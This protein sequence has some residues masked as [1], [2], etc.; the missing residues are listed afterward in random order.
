M[1]YIH[2][3]YQHVEPFRFLDLPGELRNAIYSKI[4]NPSAC[5]IDLGDGKSRYEVPTA[6]FLA[7]KQISEEA[8][9]VFLKNFT[10]VR[11]E[12]PWD[13]TQSH[14]QQ[15]GLVPILARGIMADEFE[16]FYM[17]VVI[18]APK[19]EGHLPRDH[20][21]KLLLVADDLPK[22]CKIWSL[23][24]LSYNADLNQNL[25][26]RLIMN[27]P[28]SRRLELPVDIQ[29]QLLLPFGMV[30]TLMSVEI[31]GLHNQRV[32]QQ[33]REDMVVP[34]V[35]QEKCLEEATRLKEQGNATLKRGDP[36][37]A[38]DLYT[39]SFAAMHITCLGRQRFVWADA[40]FDRL[41]RGGQFDGQHGHI[42]RLVLRIRL[43][44][45]II[46]CY[47]ELRCWEEAWFWGDRTINLMRNAMGNQDDEPFLHFP[48]AVETGKIYYRTGVA[49]K[50]MGKS[51]EAQRL[52]RVASK[53]LP[54]DKIIQ[55]ELG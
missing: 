14:L 3:D 55:A 53:Y 18:D 51:L 24:H 29:K 39:Q 1:D 7:N 19:Q 6:L 2:D 25:T 40:W 44:A 38:L 28:L 27:N 23:W 41:L 42:V 11:V 12:T 43:V 37:G 15:E 46:H 30:K 36:Q 47:N 4:Y 32:E 33:M 52:F 48:A 34:E 35:T 50:M 8:R 5:R 10:F 54:N 17:N 13:A 31:E 20:S 22:F 9:A 16:R 49:G 21:R 26:L 45:N